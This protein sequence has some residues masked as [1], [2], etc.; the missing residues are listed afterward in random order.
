LRPDSNLDSDLGLS[1]LDRVE[2]MSALEDRYQVDLSEA[3]FAAARTVEDLERILS[4]ESAPGAGYHYPRW[5]LRWPITWARL[6]AHYSLLL[7]SVFVLG[8]PEVVG[9]ENPR[10]MHGPLLVVSN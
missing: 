3:R 8:W 10:S 2:L 5:T 1:S 9:R 7:P 4:G 6:L